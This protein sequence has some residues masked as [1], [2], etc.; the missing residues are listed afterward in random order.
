M[1]PAQDQPS[2]ASDRPSWKAEAIRRGNLRITGP[3]PADLPPVDAVDEDE[4]KPLSPKRFTDSHT[5]DLRDANSST[6]RRLLRKASLDVG[7]RVGLSSVFPSH[8]RTSTDVQETIMQSSISISGASAATP[9][10]TLS[11]P[12]KR[13]KRGSLSAAFKKIFG[14]KRRVERER[15]RT[16]SPP[17]HAYHHSVN[18]RFVPLPPRVMLT[19]F[20]NRRSGAFRRRRARSSQSR[21]LEL[22]IL[23]NY[24]HLLRIS[25][26]G[27]RTNFLSL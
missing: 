7:H 21:A 20:R 1:L 22:R 11:R 23:T 13:Q 15:S 17:R 12:S 19:A 24:L 27:R 8:K 3:S 26:A 5:L 4:D 25:A 10:T 6:R 9:T 18:L 14:S 2:S 16:A